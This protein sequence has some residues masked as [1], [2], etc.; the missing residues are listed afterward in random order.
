MSSQ[1]VS[2]FEHVNLLHHIVDFHFANIEGIAGVYQVLLFS[3]AIRKL[4]HIFPG[5]LDEEFRQ[6][7]GRVDGRSGVRD[8]VVFLG[9]FKSIFLRVKLTRPNRILFT[10]H[11]RDE[12]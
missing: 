2:S 12:F 10:F 5:F 6:K 8:L 9:P 3:L 4:M 7:L 1:L 11:Q